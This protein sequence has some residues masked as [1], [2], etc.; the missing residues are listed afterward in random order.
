[1]KKITTLFV[2]NPGAEHR[3]S[4]LF[5]VNRYAKIC[6]NWGVIEKRSLDELVRIRPR[7]SSQTGC[8]S[9]LPDKF[10]K[11]QSGYVE[12]RN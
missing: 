10:L 9:G 12:S 1:V 4:I 3:K 7:I 5:V 6:P 2:K 8:K 11:P